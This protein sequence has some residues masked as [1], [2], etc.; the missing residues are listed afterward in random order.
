MEKG[1]ITKRS[2]DARVSVRSG[3]LEI[4]REGKPVGGEVATGKG[5]VYLAIDCSAS[6]AGGKL[7]QAKRG[8][9]DFFNE[10]RAKGYHVG[11]VKFET[12]AELICEPQTELPVI[13][14]YVEQL[15]RGISTDMAEGIMIAADKLRGQP[16]TRAIVV[17]TDGIPDNE[18]DALAAG[19][20]ARNEGIDMITIGTDDADQGF[21]KKLA[22]RENLS[23]IVTSENLGRGIASTA[24]MLPA[25]IGAQRL[26]DR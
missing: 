10:A 15:D 13:R 4:R 5:L 23:V 22:S 11:L 9:I 18:E 21:L 3:G 20:E 25:M 7:A 19:R 26:R 6:M 1:K 24:K 16:G 8:A 2:D 12:Y 14:R 17:V